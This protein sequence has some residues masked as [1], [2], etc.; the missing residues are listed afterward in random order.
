MHDEG[1]DPADL[2]KRTDHVSP[3]NPLH[4][5]TLETI[6]TELLAAWVG[7]D[8]ASHPSPWEHAKHIP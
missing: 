4:G 1:I 3:S 8:G 2:K 7:H 6:V 5:I